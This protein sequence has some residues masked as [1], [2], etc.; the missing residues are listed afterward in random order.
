[1]Q[2]FAIEGINNLLDDVQF[3]KATQPFQV[4][5]VKED[6]FIVLEIAKIFHQFKVVLVLL[7]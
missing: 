2:M 7:L 6:V 4:E 1:M 3:S 5:R